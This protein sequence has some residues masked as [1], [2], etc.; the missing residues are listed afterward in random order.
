[1]LAASN[2]LKTLHAGIALGAVPWQANCFA[3]FSCLRNQ[4][5]CLKTHCF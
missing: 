2:R 1:M 5:S 4:F 3:E